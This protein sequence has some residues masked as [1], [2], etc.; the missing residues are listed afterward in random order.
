MD[1][2]K[3]DPSEEGQ[4]FI[5]GI[6]NYC[7]RWCARCPFTSRCMNCS[8]ADDSFG[9]LADADVG[10]EAFW[11]RLT[12]VLR[13][14]YELL[15]EIARKEGFDLDALESEAERDAPRAE[16]AAHLIGHLSRKYADAVHHWFSVNEQL[17][18]RKEEAL[19]RI[20][21]LEAHER[22]ESEAF[23]INDAVEV[24]GWYCHQIHVKLNRAV[25][26]ASEEAVMDLEGCPKDS[27]GSAKVALIGI[28]RSI[29]AW[30]AL[31]TH[32]PD[33]RPGILPLVRMLESLRFRVE[34]QFPE[35]RSFVRPGF[36]TD[37]RTG[38]GKDSAAT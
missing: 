8:L 38:P 6:Y 27:D 22:P 31:L 28:D 30:N 23:G 12:E 15:K 26:S 5:A 21:L 10:S 35:A 16:A 3:R 2:R 19:N 32:L 18:S 4:D 29:S 17:F 24:I 14:S 13:S 25:E 9:D 11:Q 7:D 1:S 20:R 36:D 37:G 33:G 34:A